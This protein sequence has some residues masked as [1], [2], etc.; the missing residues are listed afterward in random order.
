MWST[1]RNELREI[2]WLASVTCGLSMTG[3]MLAVALVHP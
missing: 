3:V 1:V 2:V